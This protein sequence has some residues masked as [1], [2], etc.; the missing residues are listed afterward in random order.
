M[1]TEDML[2]LTLMAT[3][4]LATRHDMLEHRIP[5]ALCASAALAGLVLQVLSNGSSGALTAVLGATAGLAI[6]LPFYVKKGMAAGDVKLMAVVGIFLGAGNTILAAA[7]TLI[8]GA[9]LA[10]GLLLHRRFE[11]DRS[12]VEQLFDS[13]DA[14]FSLAVA[15]K[16]R[17]P[18]ALAIAAGT[19]LMMWYDGQIARL[20]AALLT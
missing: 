13:E 20:A 10:I 5:N 15:R 2:T 12:R 9:V 18:Y 3:L 4:A 11:S 17:F 1:S 8:T 19:G 7:L 6:F 14:R 16:E